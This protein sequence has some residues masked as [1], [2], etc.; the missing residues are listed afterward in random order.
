MKIR[1]PIFL[2]LILLVSA[3]VLFLTYASLSD[4]DPDVIINLQSNDQ[5]P[6]LEDTTTLK[7]LTWNIG[8]TGL[9]ASMDFFY[10]GGKRMRPV[11]EQVNT[12]LDGIL[13]TLVP[14]RHY[15][16]ILLQEVDRDSRRSYRTNQVEKISEEFS[17]FQHYFGQN[18]QV[19]FVPLPI[20]NPMGKVSSGLLTLSGPMPM[21]VD[22]HSFPGNYSWPMKP[23]MLDRCFLVSRYRVKNGKQLLVIN[24]HNSAYDDGTL[25][26][27]QM[28]NLKE[29]L[30]AEFNSGNYLIVGGD[31]NQTPYG[32]APQLPGHRFDTIDLTYI[33]KDYP[34]ADWSWAFDATLPTNRRVSAPYDR[35]NTLTTVIDYYLV[36]PNV[37]IE[38]VQTAD[39]QF[40]FTDHQPVELRVRLVP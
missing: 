27:Q 24:T 33:E 39:D 31:W 29:F 40:R 30:L 6:A 2:L 36:S 32:M 13:Q 22:R 38:Q 37:E 8:Y 23:F 25:R 34:A 4:Y 28:S 14:Y 16:F 19:S 15:D 5:A 26:A 20:Y 9:D 1:R 11:R 21:Q 35:R 18:Y 7:L 10:D 12:N 17:S 3:F